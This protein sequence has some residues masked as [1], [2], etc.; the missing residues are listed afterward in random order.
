MQTIRLITAEIPK[1]KTALK[2]ID[3]H[4]CWSRQEYLKGTFDIVYTPSTQVVADG[5]TKL[6]NRQK[7]LHFRELVQLKDIKSQLIVE[8]DSDSE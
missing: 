7:F 6:L 3:V 4:N 1:I 2:H 8:Y 5:F